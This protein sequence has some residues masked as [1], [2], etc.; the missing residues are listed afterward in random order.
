MSDFPSRQPLSSSETLFAEL[1]AVFESANRGDAPGL[2]VG[3]SHRGKVIY[4]RGFG[5]ASIEHGIANTPCTRMRIGSTS[6]H[7]TCV[8]ALLLMEEG[9]LSLDDSIRKYFPELPV[10]E[11][12]ATIRQLMNHTSGY[13]SYLE[14]DMLA[15]GGTFKPK[16]APMELLIRQGHANFPPGQKAIYNNGGYHLLSL[17]IERLSGLPF[18][19]FLRERVLEPLGMIDTESVPSDFEI[20]PNVATLHVPLPNGRWKRGIFP[21]EGILGE[22]ALISTVDDMLRWTAHMRG[23][24]VVGSD[25]IWVELVKP[26]MLSNGTTNSYALGLMVSPH[27][28][29][30]TIHHAGGVV[31]GA[32]EMLCVPEHELDIVIMTN[33]GLINPRALARKAMEV[34]LGEAALLPAEPKASSVNYKALVG[35]RYHTASGYSFDFSEREGILALSVLNG[36]PAAM[37]ADSTSLRLGDFEDG[38]GGPVTIQIAQI[39]LGDDAPASL[40]V[41][42]GGHPEAAHRITGVPP[43]LEELSKSLVGHYIAK[44]LNAK[45]EVTVEGDALVLTVF[46]R[47]GTNK[48]T[49]EAYSNDVFGFTIIGDMPEVGVLTLDRSEGVV[50]AFRANTLRTRQ[51]AFERLYT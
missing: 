36:Q 20:H 32:S 46:G 27:R 15:D 19:Q 29:V 24:K 2:V 13:R 33:S 30:K 21:F 37:Q 11:G 49:L 39:D 9:R 17:L 44:D 1:D 28:G 14:T 40:T 38:A 35:R 18:A 16:D 41:T 34:V 45:A 12:E 8:A 47:Y 31:G 3:I 23:P 48:M 50:T 7:F 22:G 10:L 6:K 51:I 42:E 4:R 25:E 5:L 43:A 26:T